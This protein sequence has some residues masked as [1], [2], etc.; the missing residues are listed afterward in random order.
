MERLFCALELVISLPEEKWAVR[1][2]HQV[3]V[4]GEV[5]KLEGLHGVFIPGVA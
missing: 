5:E 1:S 4:R 2:H 3:T